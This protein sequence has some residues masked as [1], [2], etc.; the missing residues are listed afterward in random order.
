MQVF[1]GG[2]GSSRLK[3]TFSNPLFVPAA[4]CFTWLGDRQFQGEEEPGNPPS[5]KATTAT[6]LLCRKLHHEYLAS[7]T[8]VSPPFSSVREEVTRGEL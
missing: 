6:G 5:S 8:A 4:F 2:S 7:S 3:P 1:L